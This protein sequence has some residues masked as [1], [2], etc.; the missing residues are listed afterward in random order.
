MKVCVLASGSK[1]NVTYIETAK[2]KS[3]I[4]VGMSTAYIERKLKEIN[5]DPKEIKRIFITHTHQDHIK[6]LR[7]FLKKYNPEIYLTEK[8]EEDLEL[9][10]DKTIYMN[11]DIEIEDLVVKPI[12]T[13]H[14]TSDSNGYIFIN[15]KKSLMY[16]T[17]TGYIHQK[18][19]NK[20]KD[21]NIYILESNHDVE[22]LMNGPYPY[23]LK[24][25]IL[26]D[27]GHLSNKDS[28]YYLSKFITKKTE[29]V[30]LAHLS[31]HNNT[32][33]KALEEYQNT[34]EKQNIKAPKVEVATQ[35]ERTEMIE[36]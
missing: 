32:K 18:N 35:N 36:I 24:Q 22:M 21:H 14:D 28:S 1:G 5:I 29:K 12:K 13:S 2:T 8:M 7:V 11:E 16:M 6:G 10:I 20:L 25:R 23:H 15:D 4:D 26:G 3:L 17:D 9:I 31:E 34:F 19:F 33:E 30:I 27:K